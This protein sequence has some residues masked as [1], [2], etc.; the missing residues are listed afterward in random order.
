MLPG[1]K[2]PDEVARWKSD[3]EA[4]AEERSAEIEARVAR[5][6]LPPDELMIY[7]DASAVVAEDA[8]FLRRLAAVR[9]PASGVIRLPSGAAMTSIEIH[10]WR[11]DR[12]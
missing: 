10:Q 9:V 1:D 2:L 7:R 5:Y 8:E 3:L 4:E 6:R 12:Q 11:Q